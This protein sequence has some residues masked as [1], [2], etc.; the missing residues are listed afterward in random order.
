MLFTFMGSSHLMNSKIVW[1][2]LVNSHVH[3]PLITALEEWVK[4]EKLYMKGYNFRYGKYMN[5]Y[6]F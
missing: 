1:C 6:V 4:F 2:V 3:Y 5:G